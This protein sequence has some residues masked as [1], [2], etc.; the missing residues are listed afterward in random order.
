[1]V[2]A[3]ALLTRFRRVVTTTLIALAAASPRLHAQAQ[4]GSFTPT[5]SMIT[6][7]SQHTATLL[8]D[9]RVLVT[10]GV[11]QAGGYHTLSSA[12]LYDPATGLFTVAASMTTGRRMHEATLLPD[13]RV[14]ITG[15][16]G[17]E[18]SAGWGSPLASAELYDPSSDRFTTTGNLIAATGGHSAL[19]L[20]SGRVL[21]VG[22]SGVGM[23]PDNVAPAQLYDPD[24]G[25]F[26]AAAAYAGRSEC[27]FCAP[28]VLLA[29]GTV[30]FLHQY[31]AQIYDPDTNAFRVT[32][33]MIEDHTGST[34]L[35]NGKGLLAG[36]E[37]DEYGRSAGAE[38]Y[39]PATGTFSRTGAMTT[40]RV[41]HSLTLLPSGLVLAAGGET[42]SCTGTM[43]SFAGT[44]RSAEIYDPATGVFH[45]IGDMTAAHE[46][47]TATVL[48][49]GRVLIA[50]GVVYGG[51]GPS[52]GSSTAEVYQ[53]DELLPAPT[54]S[55]A[56]YHAGTSYVAGP[57]DPAAVGDT[58]DIQCKGLGSGSIVLPQ[59]SLGGRLARIVSVS[60]A[61]DLAGVKTVRVQVPP[62][63][64]GGR[65]GVRLTYL[66]RSSNTV[67]M[68]VK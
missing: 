63:V 4:S 60:D 20:A 35:L 26:T 16:Y 32:G 19:L 41:W 62:G 40:G 37:S 10:G 2:H 7:R 39:D 6:A 52:Y 55:G 68:A 8:P 43:C 64:S 22:G 5:G 59:V 53:P 67:T 51:I 46:T 58:I 36:G 57:E 30:L 1:M 44:V 29:D 34:L 9:G 18:T 14:L 15:G 17:G 12:E 45:A 13:G 61:P 54:I 56:I 11:S 42:D 38:L 27:D 21:I 33:R 50:G 28:A 48:A 31:P 47:H 49:D 66:G 3:A 65:V 23:F 25:T 24:M